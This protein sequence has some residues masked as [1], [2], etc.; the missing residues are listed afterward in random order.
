MTER[1]ARIV[2]RGTRSV[3]ANDI[4]PGELFLL[5]LIIN[6]LQEYKKWRES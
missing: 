4:Q 5:L 2:D 6:D 1:K 3:V